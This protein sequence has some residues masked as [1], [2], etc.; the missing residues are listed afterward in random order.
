MRQKLQHSTQHQ[1]QNY[2]GSTVGTVAPT[3]AAVPPAVAYTCNAAAAAAD[4]DDDDDDDDEL[5]DD[6]ELHR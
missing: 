3:R 5:Q 4:D 2:S 6:D 1:L